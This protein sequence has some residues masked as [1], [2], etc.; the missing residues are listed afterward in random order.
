MGWFS[1]HLSGSQKEDALAMV[2]HL[3]T[4]LAYQQLAM[5][6]YNDA[7]AIAAGEVQYGDE[8]TQHGSVTFYQPTL[9]AQHVI[10]AVAKKI[11]LFQLMEMRH[12]EMSILATASLQEPYQEMTAAIDTMLKRARL[13]YHGLQQW[14]NNP[15]VD[16][17]TMR[18]D[19][20]ER[21]A[22]D[23][24]VKALNELI[25]KKIRLTHDE[26]LDIVQEGFNSVR[27]SLKLIP[28]SKDTFRSQYMRLISGERPR[29]FK[30]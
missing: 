29:F 19:R 20:D 28:L 4:M 27:A 24:A 13:Q 8:L 17:D 14:V 12:R 6:T 16:I 10:P 21:A 23:R 1:K 25:F 30:D 7:A 22:I 18:L 26:W 15:Q 2:R 5:E 3:Q 9:V 11:E